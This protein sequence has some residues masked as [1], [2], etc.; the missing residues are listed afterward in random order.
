[1]GPGQSQPDVLPLAHQ[2]ELGRS[3]SAQLLVPLPGSKAI[4]SGLIGI[5]ID[6]GLMYD[7]L[8]K[9]DGVAASQ[10]MVLRRVLTV[11][12]KAVYVTD[13]GLPEP[14]QM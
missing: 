14:H 1:M 4:G 3:Q 6:A 12:P 8:P 13:G 7:S 11:I 9:K 2:G 10:S 5:G